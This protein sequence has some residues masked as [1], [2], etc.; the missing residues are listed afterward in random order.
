[1]AKTL[2][3][4][5]SDLVNVSLTLVQ[6]TL[7]HKLGIS[8]QWIGKLVN[9]LDREGWIEHYAPTLPDGT[10][11]S[12]LFRAGRMLKR[13]VV[14]LQKSPRGKNLIKK[15]AKS[16]WH[17]SPQKREKQLLFL[18][19]QEEQPLT[20]ETLH[21]IPLLKTWMKRGEEKNQPT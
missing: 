9:R 16:R 10:N 15:P 20:P 5:K 18:Q 7:S 11:G 3:S 6:T 2:E 19:Q 8:R 21:R 4:N 12:T 17:F 13:V 14:M 1:M